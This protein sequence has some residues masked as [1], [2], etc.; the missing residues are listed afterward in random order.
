MASLQGSM[1]NTDDEKDEQAKLIRVIELVDGVFP[2]NTPPSIEC[3]DIV[4]FK[5]G[6]KCEYDIFQV[7]KDGND[8]YRINNGYE[9]FNI[10][11]RTPAHDRRILLSIALSPPST[12]LYF[13]IIPSS[14]RETISK[15]RKCPKDKCEPNRLTVKKCEIKFS[16]T[17][18]KDSQKVYLHKG[19]TIELEWVTKHG[20]G[21]RIEEKKYCPISGGLY[22]VEQAPDNVSNKLSS[23]GKFSKTFMEFGMSFLFRYSDGNQIHDV[24]VC[25]VNDTYRIK[26]IEI[27]DK[28]N[29]Q[30]NLIWIELNDWVVF[31]WNTKRKQTIVQIEP[32]TVDENRQ[33]S[34]EVCIYQTK[35]FLLFLI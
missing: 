11:S 15:T 18:E 10:K 7:Y 31:E 1:P 23:K 24:T 17:D 27:N 32:F 25:V 35:I 4:E 28:N 22:T 34:I 33:Q 3:D 8:Y 19:D 20:N 29:N 21:Y 14:D 5:I 6:E 9:L 30:P 12:D 26:H 2:E 16:L 13:C